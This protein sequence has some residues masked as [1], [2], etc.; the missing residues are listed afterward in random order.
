MSDRSPAAASNAFPDPRP[1]G[2]LDSFPS[3]PVLPLSALI[4]PALLTA[5]I[6]GSA[7]ERPTATDT[8]P[9]ALAEFERLTPGEWRLTLQSGSLVVERWTW[10]PGKHSIRELTVG[11]DGDGNPWRSLGVTYLDP[12]SGEIR[13]LGLS[14]DI[15]ALGR[16]V[17][18]GVTRFEGSVAITDTTMH[19]PGHVGSAT[20]VLRSTRRFDGA[21]RYRSRLDEST[22]G[23]PY[24][25]LGEWTY[26]RSLERFPAPPLPPEELRPTGDFA[27]LAPLLATDWIHEGSTDAERTRTT[28]EWVPL[29]AAM[30]IRTTAL[31]S[32]DEK[33]PT[34][35]PPLLEAL[36][37]R[38]VGHDRN[39]ALVTAANGEVWKGSWQAKEPGTLELEL[40][41]GRGRPWTVRIAREEGALR[42]RV[43][44]GAGDD[45]SLVRDL[46][47]RAAARGD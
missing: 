3:L 14:P 8:P 42:E 1:R 25:M 36:L 30:L 10:G 29:V 19:Q 6:G 46:L 22:R 15:P 32:P 7:R 33:S 5:C 43:W 16:S 28:V 23:G 27:P 21:D 24:E 39:A 31:P 41:D 12:A 13:T 26:H 47:H 18:E 44:R 4:L 35:A 20:R 38:H 11:F 2:L 37:Y 34:T 40:R 45:R 9:A 17:S